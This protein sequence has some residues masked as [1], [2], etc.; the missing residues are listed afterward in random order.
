MY[1][2]NIIFLPVLGIGKLPFYGRYTRLQFRGLDLQSAFKTIRR[3]VALIFHLD[4]LPFRLLELQQMLLEIFFGFLFHKFKENN[5]RLEINTP[6]KETRW[7]NLV[8]CLRMRVRA[9][10]TT[11]TRQD[12]YF[13]HNVIRIFKC[14]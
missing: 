5:K 2:H 14:A 10:V 11:Q 6:P 8:R 7:S 12:L 3:D 9:A 4:N 13:P 1:K